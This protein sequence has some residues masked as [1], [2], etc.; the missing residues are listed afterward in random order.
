MKPRIHFNQAILPLIALLFLLHSCNSQKTTKTQQPAQ[1]LTEQASIATEAPANDLPEVTEA[2]VENSESAPT[3]EPVT[4]TEAPVVT[5]VIHTF[6]PSDPA[7]ASKAIIDADSS[8]T[9]GNKTAASGDDYLANKFERPFSQNDMDYYPDLDIQ[10]AEIS[11]DDDFYYISISVKGLNTNS[12]NLTA[13]YGAEL[14]VDLDGSGDYLF[15]C[16]LPNFT[17]WKIDTVHAFADNNNDVGGSRPTYPESGLSGDGYESLIFSP[18]LL[19]DP[20]GLWCR[21]RPGT[22]VIVDLA[23]HKTL[24]ASPT[25]FTW[26]VW[27][28]L[29]LK[30]P[31]WFEYNDHFSY[32]EAGSPMAGNSYYPLKELFAVD[33]TCREA[34]GY[35]QSVESLGMCYVA[36]ALTAQN[37]SISG[38]AFLDGNNN[39]IKDPQ[40]T[41]L[42]SFSNLRIKL[43]QG[44]CGSS[45]TM[46][47]ES[48]SASFYFNVT[49]GIYCV[50]ISPSSN[51]TTASQK[52]V[53]VRSGVGSVVNFGYVVN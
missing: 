38:T 9:A 31:G 37:G 7:P 6:L 41:F 27:A 14:D 51:M 42:A 46:V 44:A 52:T 20:D 25:K 45:S 23:I 50:T 10:K 21:Q 32:D 1:P 53:T 30:Q 8:A 34:F 5:E 4:V 39:G 43:L 47:S 18:S 19:D 29:G 12:N 11:A 49:P 15:L 2:T 36:P 3:E 48:T 26:G 33:N 24:I 22:D 13:T 35:T 16:D 40:D 17:E 28:D